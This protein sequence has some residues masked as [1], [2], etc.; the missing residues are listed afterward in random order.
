MILV[1]ELF[2][3]ETANAIHTGSIACPAQNKGNRYPKIK[4]YLIRLANSLLADKVIDTSLRKLERILLINPSSWKHR[5]NCLAALV[6][7]SAR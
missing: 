4:G 5:A 2:Y 7:V 1:E 6:S 3:G